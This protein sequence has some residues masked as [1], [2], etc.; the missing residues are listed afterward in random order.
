MSLIVTFQTELFQEKSYNGMMNAIDDAVVAQIVPCTQAEGPGKR[1]ALWFQ[2]CPFRCV[3]CCNPEFLSTQGGTK[4]A[5]GELCNQIVRAHEE[6]G[7][8]GITLLGGEPFFQAGAALQIA[9]FSQERGLTVMIFTGNTLQE[10]KT[11]KNTEEIALLQYCDILVDGLYDA[12]QPD[13]ERRWIG[14]KNQQ[15]HFFTDRYS[16]TDDYWK[17]RN[18]LELR[19][20]GQ[21]ITINGFPAPEWKPV[22]R[23]IKPI[24]PKN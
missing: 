20:V 8:E 3:G 17:E 9:K 11:R 15:I 13:T 1:F 2:G 18:T 6:L 24:A 21:E 23:K 12:T 16:S 10:I 22:W 4:M 5:I 19:V 14:S 7:I